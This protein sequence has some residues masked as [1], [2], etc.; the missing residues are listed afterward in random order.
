MNEVKIEAK[1]CWE[2]H[3][4]AVR[5][6]HTEEKLADKFEAGDEEVLRRM[7]RTGWTAL[8]QRIW[9]LIVEETFDVPVAQVMQQITAA[10]PAPQTVV[11]VIQLVL[12]GRIQERV[13][14]ESVADE[15]QH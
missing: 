11:E 9:E 15:G 4:V 3:F 2:T 8:R 1:N 6:I 10:V 13:L 12:G 7:L 5:S 14:G